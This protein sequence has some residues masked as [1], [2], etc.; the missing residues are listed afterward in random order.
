MLLLFISLSL[1]IIPVHWIKDA[2][3]LLITVMPL[4]FIPASMGLIEH[5][6][7]LLSYP[8]PLLGATILSSLIVLIVTALLLEK[9]QGNR[10]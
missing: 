2:C 3:I 5:V 8:M 7:L 6:D 10:K 1:R 9:Y 4:F